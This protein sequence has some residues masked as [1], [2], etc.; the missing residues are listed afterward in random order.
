LA[1]ARFQHIP[2]P[3][4]EVVSAL[5]DEEG[6]EFAEIARLLAVIY[7]LELHEQ[8]Q[9]LERSYAPFNPDLDQRTPSR[10][11]NPGAEA[12]REFAE[13]LSAVLERGNYER[14]TDADI[15]HAFAT[16]SLFPIAVVVDTSVYADF[17]IFARGETHRSATIPRFYGISRKTIPVPTFDRVC[18]YIRFKTAAELQL[19]PGELSKQPFEPGTT[20]LK[21]FRNIPKADLEMVFPNCRP[22]MRPVD[23]LLFGVPALVGGIPVI[24]KLVPAAVA[25]AIVFG[26]SGGQVDYKS[27]IT[28]LGGLAVLGSYLWRQWDKFKNRRILF[29]KVLTENLYFRN[30]DTNEGVLTRVVDEAGDEE[31]KEALLGYVFA[32]RAGDWVGAEQLDANVEKY[33]SERF[34]MDIDFEIADALAKIEALGLLERDGER[35]RARP[36][37][38]AVTRLRARLAELTS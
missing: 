23:K 33:L 29:G 9:L 26:L 8:L 13:R 17:V 27:V 19:Q 31:C 10:A 16:R 6:P 21:L 7:Q 1:E 5:L 20:V 12:A 36:A 30:L 28:G 15:D 22:T 35:L 14:L 25:L 11:N 24:I 37:D 18:I 34:G 2:I 4:W 32:R 3:S 38:Q